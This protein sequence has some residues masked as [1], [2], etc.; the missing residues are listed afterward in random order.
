MRG[1]GT[2]PEQFGLLPDSHATVCKENF[3]QLLDLA[4][5]PSFHRPQG[6]FL[7]CCTHLHPAQLRA[8]MV[9]PNS[10]FGSGGGLPHIAA[11]SAN[12]HRGDG[13]GGWPLRL[14]V[15]LIP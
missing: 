12:A 10:D 8:R 14:L 11:G 5:L 3:P 13:G 1:A 4:C 2:K 9:S 7:C 15:M 6:I